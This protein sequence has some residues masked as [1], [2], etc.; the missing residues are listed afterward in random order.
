MPELAPT[1]YLSGSF[2]YLSLYLI[3]QLRNVRYAMNKVPTV[4]MGGV[5]EKAVRI[6]DFSENCR[7]GTAEICDVLYQLA[8]E[9]KTLIFTGEVKDTEGVVQIEK[10][11]TLTSDQIIAI[12][13]LAENVSVEKKFCA[14]QLDPVES[15]LVVHD[16]PAAAIEGVS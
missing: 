13:W 3:D 2:Y 8:F 6:I 14:P 1:T 11:T 15:T 4:Y 12:D 10:G 16:T 7:E 9:E 5:R